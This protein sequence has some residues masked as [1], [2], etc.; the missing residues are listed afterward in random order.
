MSK[1]ASLSKPKPYLPMHLYQWVFWKAKNLRNIV[2]Q[3]FKTILMIFIKNKEK[4]N[5][6][7]F[8]KKTYSV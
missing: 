7:I 3:F 4:N 2:K 1:L 5:K 8:Q 6:R